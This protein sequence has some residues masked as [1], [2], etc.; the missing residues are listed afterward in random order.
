MC[1][2]TVSLFFCWQT[3]WWWKWIARAGPLQLLK[4][5]CW[6]DWSCFFFVVVVDVLFII[7]CTKNWVVL[8][9]MTLAAGFKQYEEDMEYLLTKLSL[10]RHLFY[11]ITIKQSCFNVWMSWKFFFLFFFEAF[12]FFFKLGIFFFFWSQ[13]CSLTCWS[14]ICAILSVAINSTKQTNT[15]GCLQH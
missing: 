2:V 7:D 5:G 12:F 13:M 15:Q 8:N 14:K 11:F 3:A 9:C 10:W 4:V 6:R 1:N